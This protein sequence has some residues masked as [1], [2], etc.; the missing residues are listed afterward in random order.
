MG[1][2][3]FLFLATG[4]FRDVSTYDLLIESELRSGKGQT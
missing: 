2:A 1:I 3:D 4:E